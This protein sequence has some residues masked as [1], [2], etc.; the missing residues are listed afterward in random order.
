MEKVIYVYDIETYLDIFTFIFRPI[1]AKKEYRIFEISIRKNQLPELVSF[2]KEPQIHVGYNNLFFDYPILHFIINNP[3]C[4]LDELYREKDDIFSRDFPKIPEWEHLIEQVDLMKIWH[5]DNRARMTSLKWL[6]FSFNWHKVQDLPFDPTKPVLAHNFDKLIEYNINDVDFTYF[7]TGKSIDELNFRRQM[8]HFLEHNVMNYSDVKIGEYIN[9]INYEKNSG[10]SYYDFK[11]LRTTRD[12]FDSSELIPEWCSFKTPEFRNFLSE[13]RQVRFSLDDDFEFNP[14]LGKLIV[15]FMKGGLHS[16]DQA[17]IVTVNPGWYLK[18]EDVG[19]MYPKSII[20]GNLYPEH[21]GPSWRMGIKSL[22]DERVNEMK[23]RLKQLAKEK[24]KTD[25]EYKSLDSRQLAYKLAM[26]GGGYGKTGSSFSWQYDPL[27]MMKTTFRGQLSLMMFIEEMYLNDIEIIS[28]NTDGVVLHYPKEKDIIVEEIKKK[29]EETTKYELEETCYSRIIFRNV[30]H[31]LANIIDKKTSENLY[32]KYKGVFNIDVEPHKNKSQ[33]IV[34]IALSEYF[35][36]G[37]P[38][39]K[40]IRNVGYEFTN[41]KN[42]KER[43]NI[44]DYCLGRKKVDKVEGYILVTPDGNEI[45]Y[46][47]VIRYY[48]SDSSNKLWKKYKSGKM[49]AVN[50][51][52]NHTLF[53]NFEEKEDYGID[54]NYYIGECYKIIQ[55][56]EMGTKRL[57]IP[58]VTQTTLF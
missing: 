20:E 39:E 58:D 13:L 31:Y 54:Y 28:A 2:L 53:M 29:W 6:E 19:S 48:V 8:S 56:I 26:N 34:P 14:K 36:K 11:N 44:Y 7:F 45:L 32:A 52:F 10:R 16:Q 25:P 50:K 55:E 33:R 22:Y 37:V 5:Y 47:K 18:E 15:N 9:R 12:L 40:V 43:T 46:D 1:Q 35:L 4:T 49:E 3:N 30:N 23:P 17:R 21:L 27:I 42:Q 51:G 57:D 41:T 38:V 24:G